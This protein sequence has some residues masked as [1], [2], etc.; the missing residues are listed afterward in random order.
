MIS[1]DLKN[2]SYADGLVSD[3]LITRFLTLDDVLGWSEFF[4]D[5][6]AVAFFPTF[7]LNTEEARSRHWIEKQLLRYKENKFGLQALVHPDTGE[8]I[9]QCGLLL[10]E[11]DGREE[12]EVGYHIF[13]KYWGKGF[14]PEAAR[15]LMNYAFDHKLNNTIISIIHVHNIKSQR[16][17]LKNGLVQGKQTKWMDTEVFI[18]RKALE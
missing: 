5:K 12:L 17:A 13:K 11:V 9:G 7:G 16:V 3:R 1:P 6:E 15:L 4:K 8:W 2:Y 18:Y 14:A 10:Q